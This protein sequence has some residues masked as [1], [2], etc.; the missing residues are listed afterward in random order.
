[1]SHT[2]ESNQEM[3]H[4]EEST[5]ELASSGRGGFGEESFLLVEPMDPSA[6]MHEGLRNTNGGMQDTSSGDPEE[7][8]TPINAEPSPVMNP[9]ETPEGLAQSASREADEATAQWGEPDSCSEPR[10]ASSPRTPLVAPLE[11]PLRLE[12]AECIRSSKLADSHGAS[13][14]ACT[15]PKSPTAAAAEGVCTKTN[16]ERWS[17]MEAATYNE[18]EWLWFAVGAVAVAGAMFAGRS[19]YRSML[20]GGRSATTAA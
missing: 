9:N 10:I 14:K 16:P 18:N 5:E 19:L 15:T 4:S 13:G 11:G 17:T 20:S 7:R 1:M 12:P 8:P 3:H 6:S 2:P